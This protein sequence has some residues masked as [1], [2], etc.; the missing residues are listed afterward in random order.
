MYNFV[1]A[2]CEMV[3]IRFGHQ[4]SDPE[5]PAAIAGCKKS[6]E[7]GE[8]PY[9][10]YMR[11]SAF[12]QA[13]A[14]WTRIVSWW[15]GGEMVEGQVYEF[16]T[17]LPEGAPPEKGIPT[18]DTSK[19]VGRFPCKKGGADDDCVRLEW[20]S[21]SDTG[22]TA[23]PILDIV[24]VINPALLPTQ[25]PSDDPVLG[26]LRKRTEVRLLTDPETLLPQRL[27]VVE[28]LSV[29]VNDKAVPSR[30]TETHSIWTYEYELPK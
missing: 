24:G 26:S 11:S 5:T 18:T 20:V 9:V 29:T 13:W 2:Y 8:D 22:S 1:D 10:D 30:R 12:N 4:K 16:E 15:L 21:L 17:T 28:S 7:N 3:A 23:R 19:F 25:T 27:E 14:E 6:V